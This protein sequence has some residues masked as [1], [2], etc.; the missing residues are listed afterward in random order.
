METVYEPERPESEPEPEQPEQEP[1][2]ENGEE[3]G[4]NGKEQKDAKE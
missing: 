2:P 3:D 1:R 4:D